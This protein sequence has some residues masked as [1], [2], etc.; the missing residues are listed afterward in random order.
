MPCRENIGH[1]FLI[2]LLWFLLSSSFVLLRFTQ[3]SWITEN[4]WFAFVPVCFVTVKWQCSCSAKLIPDK[5]VPLLRIT[6]NMFPCFTHLCYRLADCWSRSRWYTIAEKVTHVGGSADTLTSNICVTLS[7]S[8]TNL[9]LVETSK[10]SFKIE[11]PNSMSCDNL[12]QSVCVW[13]AALHYHVR[14]KENGKVI[15][16]MLGNKLTL[17]IERI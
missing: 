9:V 7:L 6:W 3:Y 16:S 11:P 10:T 1:K 12:P 13:C 15:C 17:N 4:N 14:P 8:N 5:M 2:N